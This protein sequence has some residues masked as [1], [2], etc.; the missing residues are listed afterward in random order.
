MHLD[1][2][3]RERLRNL[4][5]ELLLEIRAAHLRTGSANVLRHWDQLQDRLRAAARTSTS[6]EGFATELARS[7]RV[8]SP[9][10]PHATAVRVLA[11]EVRE[12]GCARE[13]LDLVE[14]EWGYLI[15]L[16][17]LLSEQRKEARNA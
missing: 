12:R 8:G 9:S 1:E 15:S 2:T 17:R 11:D 10:V 4:T 7:M 13:W 6:A 5:A 14:E 16:T 3:L